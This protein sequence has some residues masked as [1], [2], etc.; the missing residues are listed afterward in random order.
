MSIG[1]SFN[2]LQTPADLLNFMNKHITYG[3]VG[4]NGKKYFDCNEEWD[5]DWFTE[6]IVQ[7]GDGILESGCGTCWDQVELERKWFQN[8]NYQFKTI[9]SWFG[10]P[11][12][13]NYPTHSFLAFNENN[14]WHW[15][16]HSF[17]DYSGVHEFKTIDELIDDVLSKQLKLA[18]N[19][20]IATPADKELLTYHFYEQPDAN[21]SVTGY[22][23]HVLGRVI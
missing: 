20:G 14:K 3:F 4:K 15:F 6:C 10:L 1:T 18:I 19:S 11:E 22:I 17:G 5:R 12:P 8:H 13:N 23:N 7:S 2:E 9:F 16:E 21:L